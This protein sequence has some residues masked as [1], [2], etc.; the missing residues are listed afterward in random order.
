M[1]DIP[2][3]INGVIIDFSDSVSKSVD[4]KIVNAL[5]HC[6]KTAIAPGYA[7]N[8]IYISSANDSHGYPSRHVQGDGKAVDISRI[9]GLKMSIHYNSND[10]VKNIT[11]A[12]QDEFETFAGRRENFGPYFKKKLGNPYSVSGHDD[13]IHISVN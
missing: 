7:L 11:N 13:H 2:S 5:N 12:I 8:K 4:Q 10:I 1:A 3:S 9:N 6:I